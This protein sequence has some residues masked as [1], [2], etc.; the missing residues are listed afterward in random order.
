MFT[1]RRSG[2]ILALVLLAGLPV[3]AQ[4][5][6]PGVL[7]RTPKPLQS[8]HLD[9]ATGTLTPGAVV[10]DRSAATVA[11][12]SNLDLGGFIGADSGGGACEWIQ[13]GTKG[14]AGNQSDL[15]S[16]IVF[17]YCSAMR[18]VGAGGPGGSARLGFYEG[19]TLGGTT[20]T[21]TVAVLTLTGLPANSTSSSIFSG[22]NC[23]FL[24]V[25][26]GALVG[27]ADGPIGYSWRFVDL[28]TDGVFAGTWPFLASSGSGTAPPGITGFID[29]YCPPGSTA[30]TIAFGSVFTSINMEIREVAD[31]PGTIV[32]F[33]ASATPNPDVIA[34]APALVGST[35]SVNLARGVA[36][37]AGTFSVNL[38]PNR[39]PLANGVQG[40]APLPAGAG[41]RIL[42]SGPV[43]GSLAGTHDGVVGSAS[44]ALP[45]QLGLVCLHFAGQATV[46]GSGVRLS[47]A[48]EG[49]TGTF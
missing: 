43:L 2:S 18:S 36:S 29:R 42:V 23:Y 45:A 19:Y 8:I 27:F 40:P 28:G 9:L 31:T 10:N 33:N 5:S 20:P 22:F 16:D 15:M 35:W 14:I 26:F 41:G 25:T 21:T 6:G 24:Q 1:C 11:D 12:F 17:A 49:T 38:R 13:A 30:Q 44:A 4:S 34:A 47:S 32:P 7:R 39:I 48:L 37:P 3:F 46:L